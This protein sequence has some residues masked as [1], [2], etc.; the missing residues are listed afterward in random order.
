M[1]KMIRYILLSIMVISLISCGG[2]E[3]RAATHLQKGHDYFAAGDFDK[4]RIEYKNVLQ[5]EPKN[6]DA[7]FSMGKIFEKNLDMG[8]A[9]QHYLKVVDLDPNYAE[10]NRDLGFLYLGAGQL[11]KAQE[12]ADTAKRLDPNDTGVLTLL[13]T[14]KAREKDY[15]AAESFAKQALDKSPNFPDAAMLLASVYSQTDKLQESAAV[16]QKA[17]DN[18]PKH[19]GLRRVLAQYYV[20][21]KESEKVVA[22]LN[23]V[24]AIDPENFAYRTQLARYYAGIDELDKAEETL[25]KSIADLPEKPEPKLIYVDFQ[26]QKKDKTIAEQ[27]LQ[28]FIKQNPDMFE[29]QFALA[30]LYKDNSELEKAT[31]VYNKIVSENGNGP[32]G[33]SAKNSLAADLLAEKKVDEALPLINEVLAENPNDNTALLMRGNI[34]LSRKDTANAKTD[35][36]TILK[37]QP[38]SRDV[39]LKLSASYLQDNERLL[40]IDN[41]KKI[42]ELYPND[43]ETRFQLGQLLAQERDFDSATQQFKTILAAKPDNKPALESLFKVQF[44]GGTLSGAAETA[45]IIQKQFPQDALGSYFLGLVAQKNNDPSSAKKHYQAALNVSPEAVEPM[46]ALVK[47]YLSQ[48]KVENALQALDKVLKTNPNNIVAQ[49]LKGEVFLSDKQYD[50][51]VESFRAAMKIDPKY[52][53]PYRNLAAVHMAQHDTAGAIKAFQEGIQ[54]TGGEPRLI[55]GLA[56]LYENIGEPESAIKQYEQLYD[57]NPQSLTA[58][59]NMAMLLV[60]YKDDSVSIGKAKK[61]IEP[62]ENSENPAFL[63]TVGWVHFKSGEFDE[64]INALEKA[65]GEAPNQPLLHYH[66]GMAHYSRGNKEQA[67]TN[68]EIA[69]NT[70]SDYKGKEE[71][72]QKLKELG[73]GG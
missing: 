32:S 16:L 49:N 44:D 6:V 53:F 14:I 7:L 40:A 21:N 65:V 71:A 10:A 73:T 72:K 68:L 64:A 60:A 36:R 48:S 1:N 4:A 5:I 52:L 55:F 11:D 54:E 34:A 9:A 62:L 61:L 8:K 56:S 37:D 30:K 3:E 69:V 66:L 28:G 27:T 47:L 26:T 2:K 19:I 63:D 50:R 67:K 57:K 59:N 22:L 17:I 25:K 18:N 29:L 45:Q 20:K 51:A 58:A 70:N 33:L 38:K 23:E 39:L 41:L 31:A 24:I 46:S 42:V 12:Y 13:G 15:L 35:F 43:L